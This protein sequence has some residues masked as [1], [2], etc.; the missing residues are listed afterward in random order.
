MALFAPA[1]TLLRGLLLLSFLDVFASVVW[2]G[3]VFTPNPALIIS[4]TDRLLYMIIVSDSRKANATEVS[5]R[6]DK[7]HTREGSQTSDSG[8]LL[9]VAPPEVV[10]F[11]LRQP[12]SNNSP[13][14]EPLKLVCTFLGGNRSLI[15]F[16]LGREYFLLLPPPPHTIL[17]TTLA[18]LA[19]RDNLD[20]P[21]TAVIPVL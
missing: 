4:I 19:L 6:I 7:N 8:Q 12:L 20:V 9:G 11:N 13:P 16:K 2:E 5:S 3:K 17:A 14:C 15:Y 1:L 18:H 10:S 21:L